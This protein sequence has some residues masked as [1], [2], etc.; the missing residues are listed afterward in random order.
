M[1]RTES[2]RGQQATPTFF[3]PPTE[4]RFARSVR[5][6][7]A[8]LLVAVGFS[9]AYVQEQLGHAAESAER[10]GDF[11]KA[12]EL[13]YGRI[14]Q[15]ARDI[16]AAEARLA[17]L[18]RDK[19]ML[20]EEVDEEDI[21]EVVSKWTGIPVSRLMEGEVQKLVH[22]EER[23]H[24]RVVVAANPLGTSVAV[25]VAEPGETPYAIPPPPASMVAT[26]E[27]ELTQ[28]ISPAGSEWF[29]PSEK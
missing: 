14:P 20:K 18:Q 11:A 6:T 7:Y 29:V 8:S 13:K 12:S 23:L 28:L 25:M 1:I 24:A 9:A 15:V 19:R 10:A 16:Q 26:L 4:R 5:H 17:D 2:K 22:M 21:A 27:F 3:I